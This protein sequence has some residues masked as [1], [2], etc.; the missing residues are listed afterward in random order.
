MRNFH[1]YEKGA[2]RQQDFQ[3]QYL[4][5]TWGATIYIL[6]KRNSSAALKYVKIELLPNIWSINSNEKYSKVK[7]KIYILHT[8][9]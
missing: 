1:F 5:F 6:S 8:P 3:L 4:Q 9:S 7:V 2:L